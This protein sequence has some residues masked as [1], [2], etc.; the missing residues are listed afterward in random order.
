MDRTILAN[1]RTLLAYLRTALALIIV[2]G[3]AIKFFVSPVVHVSGGIFIVL[4]LLVMV[5]GVR[6][7]RRTN[8]RIRAA[9]GPRPRS[10]AEAEKGSQA[11]ATSE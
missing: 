6:R 8:R 3:S 10:P 1:E 11:T 2:G 9:I 7:F 4:G 5:V